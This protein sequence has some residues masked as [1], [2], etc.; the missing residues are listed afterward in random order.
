[1]RVKPLKHYLL[2]LWV[3]LVLSGIVFCAQRGVIAQEPQEDD[4]TTEFNI[5][6]CRFSSTGVNPYFILLPC[7]QL[8]LEGEEDEETVRVEITVLRET[9][10]I[11]LNGTGRI[12]TRVVQERE[13]VDDELVEVSR[14]FFAICKSTNDVFYFGEEV[15]IY[16]D[17][18]IVSHEGSWRA[19]QNGAKPGIIMPGT[20]LLGSR[21]YQELAPDVA[22]DRAEHIAM[23]LTIETETGTF[24]N[25]VEIL[26]TS[27]LDPD[28]ESTKNYARGIGLVVDDVVKLVDYG[29]VKCNRCFKDNDNDD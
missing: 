11:C 2:P 24:D 29:F 17:G 23:N 5:E 7:Y 16:E 3:M 27:P 10:I 22:L 21:Y 13:W 8:V 26:E 20:F 14:N 15:D 4:F 12:K 19:G 18:E 28:A 6:D 1:M 25:C 9:E